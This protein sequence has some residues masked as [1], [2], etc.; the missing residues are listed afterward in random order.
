M[1]TTLLIIVVAAAIWF[2]VIYN[3]LQRQ[4][5]AVKQAR[6][7]IT[8]SLKKR[9]DLAGQLI[10]IAKSYGDH[11]KLAQLAA[12]GNMAGIKEATDSSRQIDTVISHVSSLAMAFPD[13]KANATYQQLMSQLNDIESNLQKKRERYNA[14]VGAYNTYRS[15][16]PQAFFSAAIGFP[17]APFYQTD[18][19]GIDAIAEFK[20]DDGAMLKETIQKI[21]GKASGMVSQAGKQLNTAIADRHTPADGDD[22]QNPSATPR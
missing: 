4:G 1:F 12:S 8:A 5:N 22:G 17:E 13:L 21:G 14:A 18:E 3:S 19:N 10:D 6:A 9:A 20:T 7:D 15:S 16:L 2:V 11:E